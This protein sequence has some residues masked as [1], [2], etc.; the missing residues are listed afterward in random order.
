MSVTIRLRRIGRK[1]Q[2][3][4]RVVVADSRIAADGAYLEM[5]GHY[6]STTRPAELRLDLTRLDDWVARG[7]TMSE[8]VK[9]LVSKARKGGDSSVAFATLAAEP[10]VAG[11]AAAEPAVAGPAAAEPAVAGPAAAEPAVA[12]PAAAEPAAAESP[13]VAA[14]PAVPAAEVAAQPVEAQPAD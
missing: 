4:Y 6:T 9:S 11:P 5:L 2:P 8:T 14:A 13:A 3:Y 12:G 10:A 1:K 7:A